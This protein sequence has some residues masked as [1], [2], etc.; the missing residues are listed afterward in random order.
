MTDITSGALPGLRTGSFTVRP[1]GSRI[2]FSPKNLLGMTA[3]PLTD[4]WPGED[5]TD[6]AYYDT[7]SGNL[8]RP[9]E[10]LDEPG[11]PS[12]AQPGRPDTG[13]YEVIHL[14]GQ[15]AV[16]VPITYFLRLRAG[17]P[18]VRRGAAGR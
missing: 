14:G 13:S 4:P 10:L 16:V 12:G 8:W 3:A 6:Y 17:A 11:Q 15:A 2:G 9:G 18:R 5:D 1:A 7:P